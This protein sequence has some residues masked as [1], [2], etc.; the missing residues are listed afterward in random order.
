MGLAIATLNLAH[1]QIRPAT[2]A[3]IALIREALMLDQIPE[4]SHREVI[5]VEGT[6]TAPRG[7]RPA[8]LDSWVTFRPYVVQG[9]L[10]TMEA[11]FVSG[12]RVAEEYVWSV[13]QF[14]YW[15]WDANAA[16][17]ETASR[18]RI[19]G[20]AV[21]S[22]EPIPSAAMAFI[23][24]H[25]SELLALAYEHLEQE[26]DESEP[27]RGWIL[28]YREDSRFRMDR[29]SITKSSAPDFGFAYSAT[30]RATGRTEGPA[31]TFSVTPSGFVIHAVGRWIA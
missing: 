13:E 19:P 18:S 31:V 16:D 3:E 15:N 9:S 5:E 17:C 25:A 23:L 22:T 21:Q 4:W 6:F 12:I 2:E 29:I 24:A 28:A 27:G 20:S 26:V 8:R 14:A 1:A 11:S 7:D 10:C 30:Y